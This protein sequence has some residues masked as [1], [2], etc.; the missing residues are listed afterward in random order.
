MV[1]DTA[2][3]GRKNW[4]FWAA[5]PLALFFLYL[6]LRGLDWAAFWKILSE[7]RY[8]ILFLTVP[9]ASLNYLLRALRWR[10]FLQAE[11][12]VSLPAVFW[13]N[14]I[15][16]TGNAYLP[17]RAGEVFRSVA[18]GRKTGLGASFVLATALSERLLDVVA[19]VLIGSLALLSQGQI[20]GVLANAVWTMAAAGVL[21]LAV[22]LLAPSQEKL[23]HWILGKLPLPA[24]L[25][26]KIGKFVSR[27]LV[28]MR[29][30]Q[31]VRRM[32]AFI[33]LTIVIW[34]V[35]GSTAV[36][37][38]QII[39]QSINLAQGLILLSALGLSSAIP[40]TPGYVGVFQ[41]VA[42]SVLVPFGFSQSE[43]VAYI[44]ISQMV[45]YLV[46]TFWGVIGAFKMR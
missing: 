26:E 42:V 29:S 41:F 30:L 21:G 20:S 11:K 2:S 13:A 35:D 6:A 33:A 15:G 14:M 37:G 31:S 23:I 3:P 16:Y 28:G 7:G 12:P 4:L 32:A 34:V 24:V 19:L 1:V 36:L 27:F 10:I 39:S 18:L 25:A 8:A 22:F 45:N 46:V 9:I 44:L 40:S 5:L 38:V 17:A 43:A